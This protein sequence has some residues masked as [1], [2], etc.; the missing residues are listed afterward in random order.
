MIQKTLLTTFALTLAAA[1]ALVRFV[2]T[3]ASRRRLSVPPAPALVGGRTGS[4]CAAGRPPAGPCPSIFDVTP[5]SFPL[6]RRPDQQG[7]PFVYSETHA[8]LH[9]LILGATGSG[10]SRYAESQCR[11]LIRS[12]RGFCFIDPEGDTVEN[13]MGWASHL[14]EAEGTDAI[15]RQIVYVEL[16]HAILV[17][18]DPFAPPDFS[19]FPV[20]QH[21]AAYRAWLPVKVDAFCEIVQSKQGASD[22]TGMARLQR[23]LRTVLTGVGT[24]VDA[25]GRHL[26]LSEVFALLDCE[27]TRHDTVYAVVAPYLP[28]FVRA[29]FERWRGAPRAQ[30]LQETESTLNRLRSLLSPLVMAVFTEPTRRMNFRDAIDG[31]MIL[32]VN[33]RQ[34]DFLS[35]DQQRTM[36]S[37]FVHEIWSACKV[38]DR[39]E[40][41]VTPYYLF[42]DEAHLLM[43]TSG[44]DLLQ[45][46]CRG[47]K[48]KVSLTLIGQYLGQFRNERVDMIPAVLN[49]CRTFACF[50]HSNPDDLE[51]LKQYFGYP[52]LDFT[53]L[54]QVTDRP[55]GHE[56][57]QLRDYSR[58]FTEGTN[59]STG[60]SVNH[61]V[62]TSHQVTNSHQQTAGRT[63]ST[64]KTATA[65][66]GRS[67]SAGGAEQF[68]A[69]GLPT[70][71]TQSAGGAVS[72][73]NSRGTSVTQADQASCS[74]GVSVAQGTS[75]QRGTGTNEGVGGNQG[76]TVS[77]SVKSSLVPVTREEWHP[78][79]RLRVAV[80]DQL[81]RV[82]H[83][84]STLQNRQA[85]VR[86]N[87]ETRTFRMDVGDVPDVIPDPRAMAA[88]V[89]EFKARVYASHGYYFVPDL[90]ATAETRRLD[91]WLAPPADAPP[92][93][94]DHPDRAQDNGWGY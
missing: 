78:T 38:A 3:A 45:I 48:Y 69:H 4:A 13:L 53:E 8:S 47:R 5:F 31:R 66:S 56:L 58:S 68:D 65:T 60:T 21:D 26:P 37:M 40:R 92:A 54:M 25:S 77:E 52:N 62:G 85:L 71:T 74:T 34:T 73:A 1:L 49:L 10:K 61:T 29:E 19:A 35:A 75:E 82:A 39:E 24:A 22:F 91:A 27:H 23:V 80:D 6:G 55:A 64:G 44:G 76:V 86:L 88:R 41:P 87:G 70:G 14:Q 20:D 43:E 79:G 30:R 84:I 94:R 67:A 18:F 33:L 83:V 72:A 32:L 57:V 46:L 15:C 2:G 16:S 28:D 11:Y 81:D 89:R 59:W 9:Q 12:H 36:A 90:S 63:T 51:I 17:G 93:I 7:R 42:I 50:L